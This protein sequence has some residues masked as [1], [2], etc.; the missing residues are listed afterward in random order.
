MLEEED[1]D[2]KLMRSPEIGSQSGLNVTAIQLIC[3]FVF[4]ALIATLLWVL[5]ATARTIKKP[6]MCSGA[7]LTTSWYCLEGRLKANG[8][9]M[10]CQELTAASNVLALGTRLKLTYKGRSVVVVIDD[11][12]PFIQG[13]Q[14]DA[15]LG[16]ARLLQFERRG[17]ACLKAEAVGSKQDYHL[18]SPSPE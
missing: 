18:G 12:G 11:R 8:K 15:S 10:H 16:A 7:E 6:P 3:T 9:P 5:T 2:M 4:C 1:A 14:L 17:V 13:R